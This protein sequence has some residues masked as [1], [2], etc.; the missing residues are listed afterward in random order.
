M[1][2]SR[3][4]NVWVIAE[5]RDGRVKRVTYELLGAARALADARRANVWCVLL[6]EGVTAAADDCIARQADTVLVVD[7]P[8]LATFV[9]ETYANVLNRLIDRYTPEIV[10]CGATAQGRALIPRVAVRAVCGLT[11]DCTGLSIA[12]DTGLLL[13]TRPALGG[14]IFATIT[15]A[16]HC[17]QMATVR[18]RVMA[19]PQPD[20]T[21]KGEVLA[22]SLDDGLVSRR[23][24]V[25]ESVVDNADRISLADA[26]FI[27]AGGRGLRGPEGFGLLRDVARLVDGAV[28]A[29]RAAVDAGWIDY[30]YQVGQTGQTVQPK[31]YLACGISGQIQHLVGMQSSDIIISVNTDRDAPMMKLADYAVVGDLFEVLPAFIRK[32]KQV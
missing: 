6:G 13:Q 11:A 30:T 14:N 24:C 23:M 19:E 26:R 29:S 25:L 28:S 17:P 8:E 5:Q 7:H 12:E 9:D 16:N 2:R 1:D 21:R 3:Y 22:E 32:M 31:V 4:R 27:I 18:P 20:P 15:S 10:L